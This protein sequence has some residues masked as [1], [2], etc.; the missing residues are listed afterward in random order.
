RYGPLTV[1]VLSSPNGSISV[2]RK[3]VLSWKPTPGATEYKLQ[4]AT[5]AAFSKVAVATTIADTNLQLPTALAAY[6][7][8]YW[9]VAALNSAFSSSYSMMDSFTTGTGIL[10]IIDQSS[11]IARG[12]V[13]FQ[14]YPN[15]FN[16]STIIEYNLP[17]PQMVTLKVF[18]ILGQ[19][20]AT[21]VN[22]QMEPGFYRA[23]FDGGGLASGVYFYVL[24][25]GD[26]KSTRK[27][28]LLR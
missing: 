23:T 1:P 2:P 5:N 27:M 4:V 18:D 21:L 7:K 25:A 26:F 9:R 20:I 10:G 11:E 28:V 19:G 6:T 3:A 22:K 17:K 12:F 16:P 15:P 14:N 24:R 13:L 8:Y